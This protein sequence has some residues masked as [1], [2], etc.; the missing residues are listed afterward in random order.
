MMKGKLYCGIDLHSNNSVVVLIDAE[1]RVVYEK[2]LPNAL[3]AILFELSRYKKKIAGVVVESTFNWYWLVD[4]LQE[5]GYKVHLAN[6]AAIKQYEGLKYTDDK[7]DARWLAHVLRLGILPEG[8]IYPKEERGVRDLLRKRSQ[9]VRQRTTHILSIQNLLSRNTGKSMSSAKI[10]KLTEMELEGMFESED[11]AMAVLCNLRAVKFLTKEI[12]M[13]EKAVLSKASIRP[14][15][16]N[17]LSVDGIGKALALTI[18]LEAG[19]IS[20][21]GKVGNFASYCRCVDS[22]RIS[23]EKKKGAN[24]GKN[25]NKYLAW[26]FVEAATFAVRYNQRIGR[27]YERKKAKR[28]GMVAIKAVAHKL[29]RACYHILKDNV[30]FSVELAFG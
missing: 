22:K 23:N 9:L 10:K 5:E 26:A 13:L 4:G 17:L 11:V 15:Y 27:F 12:R 6:T 20:R 21:F 2:R 19:D 1:N 24:N 29:A 18:M 25:G 16:E 8:Y 3:D 7:S 28:N 14:E 30:P